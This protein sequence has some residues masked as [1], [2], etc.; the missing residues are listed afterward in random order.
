[1]EGSDAAVTAGAA[2]QQRRQES[3]AAAAASDDSDAE[4]GDLLATMNEIDAAMAE[5]DD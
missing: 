3:L 5:D 1:V 4:L 2:A